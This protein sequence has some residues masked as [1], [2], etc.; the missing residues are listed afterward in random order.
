MV[1]IDLQAYAAAALLDVLSEQQAEQTLHDAMCMSAVKLCNCETT[2]TQK[3][4]QQL[5]L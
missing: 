2:V 4:N 5:L 3:Q 1:V